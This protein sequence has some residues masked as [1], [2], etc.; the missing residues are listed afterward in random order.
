MLA[1]FLPPSVVL[2]IPT[3]TRTHFS[4]I[5]T[6]IEK[7]QDDP[8]DIIILGVD[9]A[10]RGPVLG[11]MVY[12]TAY[13]RKKDAHLLKEFG[14]DDSKKLTEQ[15]RGQLMQG[16]CGVEESLFNCLGWATTSITARDI[17]AGMLRPRQSTYNLNI[18]AHD[19]TMELID[20]IL[21][22]GVKVQEI[23]IDTVGPPITYQKKLQNR[24]PNLKVTV[25]KKADSLFPI[26]SAASIVAKVTRDYSLLHS[27]KQRELEGSWGSGYP[28]DP[29][30][31]KWLNSE[32]DPL[33]GWDQNVRY[34]WQTSKDA[35]K[36]SGGLVMTWEDDLEEK[37]NYGD[38]SQMFGAKKTAYKCDWFV[39]KSE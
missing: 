9:E 17:S 30:T 27:A 13:I 29:R 25:T 24:F 7:S 33:F 5:P 2:P 1:D 23:Y 12:G 35:M 16:I 21:R 11:P 32:V 14:F 6:S 34:S 10:G 20:S 4:E 22:R 37:E 26:V 19:V 3:T 28:S 39:C 15:K 38:V 8:E 31:T 18:Q 36:R